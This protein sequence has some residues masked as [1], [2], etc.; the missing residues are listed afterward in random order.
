MGY[1]NGDTTVTELRKKIAALRED[2]RVAIQKAEPE[3][4][5][6]YSFRTLDGEVSLSELFGDKDSLFVV[7]NMGRE[8]L[9]CTV[10]ADGFNGVSSHLGDRAAFVISTP[11]EPK[12][13]S[14]FASSRGWQIPVVSHAGS[15]F[16]ADMG[17]QDEEWGYM[18]GISV[19][20]R[21]ATGITRVS[22]APFGPGDDFSAIWHLFDLLPGG[23]GDWEPKYKY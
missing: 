22:D 20:S 18:P 2:L 3:T 12:T 7:H 17:Y 14:A 11:D 6:D 10:W 13:Q 1:R 9:Y 21:G 19:F 8:C 15:R 4:V 5:A 23:K 16:A